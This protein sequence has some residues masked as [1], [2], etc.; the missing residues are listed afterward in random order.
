MTSVRPYTPGDA[1]NRIHWRSSAR[2]QELQVKEFDVEPSADLWLYLDLD[3]AVHV[4]EGDASTIETAVSAAA[5]LAAQALGDARGV[6]MEVIGLRRVV[7]ATERGARQQ[8]R[9]LSL[10]AVAQAEGETPL[11]EMLREGS[12]HIRKGTAVLVLTPSLDP[13]WVAP[14]AALRAGGVAPIAC[15]V[16]PFAHL[17]ASRAENGLEPADGSVQE[18][19][20]REL[21]SMLLRLAEYDVRSHVL[22]PG[23]PLGEQLLSAR[24]APSTVAT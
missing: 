9:I 21:Q 10:L 13:A 5:A 11:A 8:H 12:A 17:A 2:H 15:M 4:G 23:V 24:G 18:R 3:H 16:D 1:F 20:S 7:I 22:R 14:L 19:T 6:G